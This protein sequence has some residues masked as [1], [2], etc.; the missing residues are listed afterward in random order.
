MIKPNQTKKLAL[1]TESIRLLTADL[2]IVTGG[3][4]ANWTNTTAKCTQDIFCPTA[5]GV[6]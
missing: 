2:S 4:R 1:A 3:Q 5:S 6:C